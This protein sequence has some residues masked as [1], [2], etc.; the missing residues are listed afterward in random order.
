MFQGDNVSE[1]D[2]QTINS[3]GAEYIITGSL[4]NSRLIINAIKLEGGVTVVVSGPWTISDGTIPVKRKITAGF[5]NIA[6]G[7]GSF[8]MGDPVGGAIVLAGEALA[9]G[10]L[11]AEINGASVPAFGENT[12]GNIGIFAV[13]PLSVA[14]GFYRPFQYDRQLTQKNSLAMVMTHLTIAF[15]PDS[16]GNKAVALLYTKQF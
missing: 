16:N 2:G 12:I 3:L 5:L 8:T 9:A 14:F 1:K 6:G 4:E 10:M 7:L 13:L 15:I 11:I